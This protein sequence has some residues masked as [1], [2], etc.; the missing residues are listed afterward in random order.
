MS[1]ADI[2]ELNP[3]LSDLLKSR[4]KILCVPSRVT[5]PQEIDS[6]WPMKNVHWFTLP[7][8][9]RSAKLRYRSVCTPHTLTTTVIRSFPGRKAMNLDLLVHY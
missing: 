5:R 4:R 1:R 2:I 8:K 3:Q 7:T 6:Q 9:D